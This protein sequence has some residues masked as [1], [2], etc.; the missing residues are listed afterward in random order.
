MNLKPKTVN[1]KRILRILF[2]FYCIVLLFL[3]VLPI[4]G[5]SSLLNGTYIIKIRLDYFLH[6]LIFLP[7]LPLARY[8]LSE[9][10]QREKITKK[11]IVLIIIGLLFALITEGIQFYLPYRTFNVNDLIGN[12][13][14]VIVGLPIIL[15]IATRTR[16]L[17][18]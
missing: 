2:L 6:A 12:I 11:I 1:F 15:L 17:E 8:S 9:T 16:N 10:S 3:A 14:G 5:E 18:G 4:H 13:F 7:F